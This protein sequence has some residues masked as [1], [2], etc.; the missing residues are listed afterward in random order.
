MNTNASASLPLE[1]VLRPKTVREIGKLA[2][3]AEALARRWAQ[4]WPA[5]TRQLELSGK[6]LAV[7]QQRAEEESLL[8]WRGRVRVRIQALP[9]SEI[10]PLFE[11]APPPPAA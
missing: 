10:A 11:T 2:P 6:L 1:R 9:E 5:E 4:Q 7:L 3:H 8:Q